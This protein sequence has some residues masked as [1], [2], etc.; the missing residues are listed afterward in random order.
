MPPP[1]LTT[2]VTVSPGPP[3]LLYRTLLLKLAYQKDSHIRARV[4][5]AEPPAHER[6]GD[7]RPVGPPGNRRGLPDR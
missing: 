5:G 2:T 1:A 7:P 3:D 4:P 6:A